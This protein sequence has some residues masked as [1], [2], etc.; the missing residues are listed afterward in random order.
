MAKLYAEFMMTSDPTKYGLFNSPNILERKFAINK[1]FFSELFEDEGVI[2]RRYYFSDT[3]SH[4]FS[5]ALRQV[6][7]VVAGYVGPEDHV[8]D[9]PAGM[10]DSP[11]YA[12]FTLAHISYPAEPT[13]IHY[14]Y[15]V[16]QYFSSEHELHHWG[17]MPPY[18]QGD[19][20]NVPLPPSPPE[21]TG[22]YPDEDQSTASKNDATMHTASTLKHTPDIQEEEE[23]DIDVLVKKDWYSGESL[24][25]AGSFLSNGKIRWF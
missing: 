12:K 13:D 20:A 23:E 7:R 10:A 16:N 11:L 2:K 15:M 24:N 5:D 3:T 19:Y 25:K 22:D 17:V 4:A 6:C 9:I 21:S 1:E 18:S 8:D 14:H